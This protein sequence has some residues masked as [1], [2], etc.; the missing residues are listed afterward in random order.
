MESDDVYG[1]EWH[2]ILPVKWANIRDKPGI[3][4]ITEVPFVPE[5][6]FTRLPAP[7]VT[8]TDVKGNRWGGQ[9]LIQIITGIY[10]RRCHCATMFRSTKAI[11]DNIYNLS[12]LIANSR[13]TF[14]QQRAQMMLAVQ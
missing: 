13:A 3:Q 6:R 1:R 9:S 11:E 12:D 5:T 2:V 4:F 8:E 14:L 10:V 7:E